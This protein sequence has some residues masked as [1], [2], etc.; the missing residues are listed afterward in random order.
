MSVHVI[1]VCGCKPAVLQCALHRSLQ[2][3]VLVRLAGEVIRISRSSIPRNL[4]IDLG[5]TRLGVLEL[6]ENDDAGAFSHHEAVTCE[7]EG[8]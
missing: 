7:I 8:A 6:L 5:A 2:S 1:D 3:L 4:A